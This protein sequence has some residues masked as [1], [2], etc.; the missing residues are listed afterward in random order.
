MKKY[1]ILLADPP[2]AFSSR[3][4][5][6][7]GRPFIALDKYYP[8][9]SLEDMKLLGVKRI[10]DN[11]SAL[12]LWCVSSHLAGGIDLI[13]S[14]GFRFVTVAFVW[15]KRYRNWSLCKNRGYWTMPSCELCLL[16]IK[17]HPKRKRKNILQLLEAIR[18]NHSQK[19]N[20]VRERIVELMGDLPRIE[21]F[22]RRKVDGWD[23]WGNEVESDVEL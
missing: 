23:C 19:P 13:Q 4:G 12:F 14:W 3:Q 6:D 18:T 16:G 10:T 15:I 8:S 2:W 21:L 20:E 5:Q 11:N 9:M 22:A 1:S 17:G 7:K